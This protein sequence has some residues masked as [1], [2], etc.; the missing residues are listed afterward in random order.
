MDCRVFFAG[1]YIITHIVCNGTRPQ[2]KPFGLVECEVMQYQAALVRDR[3]R[4]RNHGSQ[5][6]AGIRQIGIDLQR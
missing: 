6:F 5:H 3:C 2:G 4:Q 1:H